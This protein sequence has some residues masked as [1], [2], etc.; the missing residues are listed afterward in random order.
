MDLNKEYLYELQIQAA[1]WQNIWNDF[2]ETR[3]L[4]FA[5]PNGG[6]RTKIEAM[7][8]KASGLVPG[9]PDLIFVWHGKTY[10]LEGK[11]ATGSLSPAQ[12]RVHEAWTP[13]VEK[14]FVWRTAIELYNIV[15]EII[16]K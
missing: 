12:I 3:Y 14:I 9:I 13:H 11:T 7:Q 1:G 2:P 4:L 6:K 16:G 8:F 10:G 5:V 15:K